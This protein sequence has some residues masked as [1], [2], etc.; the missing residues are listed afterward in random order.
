MI[1]IPVVFLLENDCAG[2]VQQQFYIIDSSFRP[3]EQTR[4]GSSNTNLVMDPRWA[5]DTKT[6]RPT[7]RGSNITLTLT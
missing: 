4:N 6:D 7:N 1:M 5:L 2:E 3:H